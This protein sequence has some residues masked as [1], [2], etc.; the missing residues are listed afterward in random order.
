[1]IH[2]IVTELRRATLHEFRDAIENLA[3]NHRRPRGPGLCGTA[4]DA[5][6]LAKVFARTAGNVG[7]AALRELN[8]SAATRFAA[9]ERAADIEL[10]STANL[11]TVGTV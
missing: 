7:N 10:G 4:R 11:K 6:R 5:N 2:E 9:W 1:M 3:T 8:L